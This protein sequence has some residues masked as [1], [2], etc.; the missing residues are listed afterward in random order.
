MTSLLVH[1]GLGLLTVI[2][3][4]RVNRHLY[5]RD[6]P[7]SGV[8]PLEGLYYVLAIGSVCTGWYF[9]AQ[10]VFTYPAEASWT[11][12]RHTVTCDDCDASVTRWSMLVRIPTELPGV[13]ASRRIAV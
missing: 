9:N 13:V 11:L 1:A 7:G 5:A 6:W 2:V 12:R 8:T 3:F 10:Y 4:F